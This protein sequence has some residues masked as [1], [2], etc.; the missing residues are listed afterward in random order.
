MA[1]SMPIQSTAFC[2]SGSTQTRLVPL[3]LRSRIC[4]TAS[5]TMPTSTI[6]ISASSSRCSQRSKVFMQASLLGAEIVEQAVQTVQHALADFTVFHQPLGGALRPG[7]PLGQV[8]G[9]RRDH[10]QA[11]RLDGGKSLA[12]ALPLGAV[13][14]GKGGGQ[15]LAQYL[16]V[17]FGDTR[18]MLLADRQHAVGVQQRHVSEMAHTGVPL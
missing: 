11:L 1:P 9:F 6:T 2:N 13:Q 4:V 15:Y 8:F 5:N 14:F 12:I 7:T 18:Q 16:L 3:R 17:R 10:F